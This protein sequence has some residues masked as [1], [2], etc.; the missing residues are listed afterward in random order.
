MPFEYYWYT[1]NNLM[2]KG[3]TITAGIILA[4][5]GLVHLMGWVAYWPLADIADLPYKT[6]LFNGTWNLGD[7]GMRIFSVLWLIV[8]L[9][10]VAAAIGVLT[11]QPWTAQ[12]LVSATLLS[13]VITGLDWGIAFL[14]TAIDG[15]VLA[16]LLVVPR[17]RSLALLT[18]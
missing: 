3:M 18:Q 4:L 6:T 11:R 15:V 2:G 7:G 13:L 16:A 8:A 1:E 14:G 17:I 5:H 10:F 12:V 9:G